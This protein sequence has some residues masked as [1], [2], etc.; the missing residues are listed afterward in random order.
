MCSKGDKEYVVIAVADRSLVGYRTTRK[1]AEALQSVYPNRRT[2]IYTERTDC[3]EC[4][5]C[6]TFCDV[7][8][9]WYWDEE[10]CEFH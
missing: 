2:E 8:G 9:S 5:E 7:C 1:E 6:S 4:D 3:Q 10:P